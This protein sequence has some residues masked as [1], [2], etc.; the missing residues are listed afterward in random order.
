MIPLRFIYKDGMDSITHEGW[1]AIK[2][3]PK[4][5]ELDLLFANVNLEKEEKLFQ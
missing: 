1:Y 2:T 4:P 3:N 5:L